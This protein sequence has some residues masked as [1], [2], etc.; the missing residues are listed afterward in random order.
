MPTSWCTFFDTIFTHIV[1]TTVIFHGFQTILNII[2]FRP[3]RMLECRVNKL[4][5]EKVSTY[6]SPG[7]NRL[8]VNY[9]LGSR[10]YHKA[11]ATNLSLSFYFSVDV[12]QVWKNHWFMEWLYSEKAWTCDVNGITQRGRLADGNIIT[13][14][15]S[16]W[17]CIHTPIPE[18][19]NAIQITG[20]MPSRFVIIPLH[21]NLSNSISWRHINFHC[22]LLALCDNGCSG[23]LNRVH[24]RRLHVLPSLKNV[25]IRERCHAQLRNENHERSPGRSCDFCVNIAS[26]RAKIDFLLHISW[27]FLTP[28]CRCRV[29]TYTPKSRCHTSDAGGLVWAVRLWIFGGSP[30]LYSKWHAWILVCK[31]Y[32]TSIAPALWKPPRS[33]SAVLLVTERPS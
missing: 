30:S 16:E 32:C 31:M 18:L 26:K 8:R 3:K 19:C 33:G 21:D 7:L 11:K 23:V 14:A 15:K 17:L 10:L 29:Q 9:A 6:G 13:C 27:F 5:F 20:Q 28:R 1:I 12:H 25:A 22:L 2:I 24:A 4:R